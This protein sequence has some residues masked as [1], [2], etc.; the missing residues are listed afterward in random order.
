MNTTQGN[1]ANVPHFRDIVGH[2]PCPW[3]RRLDAALLDADV[4]DAVDTRCATRPTVRSAGV[5]VV[6]AGAWPREQSGSERFRAQTS[7][8]ANRRDSDVRRD[9]FRATAWRA[10]LPNGMDR[11]TLAGR[12]RCCE[13]RCRNAAHS[14]AGI[15][16]PFGRRRRSDAFGRRR[17]T[18][19]R[20]TRRRRRGGKKTRHHSGKGVRAMDTTPH[21]VDPPNAPGPQPAALT[22]PALRHP[23]EEEESQMTD[24]RD[25]VGHPPCPWQRRFRAREAGRQTHRRAA[26]AAR[27]GIGAQQGALSVSAA[28][29]GGHVGQ[30]AHIRNTSLDTG[31]TA[32]LRIPEQSD[33]RFRSKVI[34]HSGGK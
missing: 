12:R 17:R 13:H 31:E 25:L 9:D 29:G 27:S 7:P 3:Q 10:V 24:G 6:I 19:T 4:P 22:S 15:E 8:A 20:R 30:L 21:D 11:P 18:R 33:H 26:T 28:A 14:H 32:E 5:N 23:E 16:P 34:S 2:A 1:V